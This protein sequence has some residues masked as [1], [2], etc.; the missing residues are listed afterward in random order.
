[1]LRAQ[2]PFPR[3]APCAA[4]GPKAR[5]AG[6]LP[7]SFPTDCGP[8]AV[9]PRVSPEAHQKCRVWCHP[10]G[11]QTGT[12]S[13]QYGSRDHVCTAVPRLAGKCNVAFPWTRL[14]QSALLLPGSRP[15]SACQCL[16]R[17]WALVTLSGTEGWG[18]E[19]RPCHGCRLNTSDWVGGVSV[20]SLH[21]TNLSEV[22]ALGL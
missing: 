13:L 20:T 14:V 8:Q 19:E 7:R 4:C 17:T 21:R 10:V 3:T 6:L 16:T 11:T 5:G 2:N 1:M 9:A 22:S 18:R 12:R 15:Q